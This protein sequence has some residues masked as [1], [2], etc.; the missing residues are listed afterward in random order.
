MVDFGM[1]THAVYA[2]EVTAF[3][4]MRLSYEDRY[5]NTYTRFKLSSVLVKRHAD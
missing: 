4:S 5:L 2:V 3:N 1:D